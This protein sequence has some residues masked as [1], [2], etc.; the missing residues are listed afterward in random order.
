[1]NLLSINKLTIANFGPFEGTHVLELPKTGLVLIKGRVTE[2]EDG[3]GSGKSYLLKAL[4]YLFGGCADPGT[5][6]Q[7][8]FTDAPPEA[9]VELETSSGLLKIGRKKG[10]SISGGNYKET[11]KGKAAE[12]E[13]TNI[14]GIDEDSRSIVTYRGQGKPGLFLSLSDEKKKIFLS[15]LLGLDIYQNLAVKSKLKIEELEQKLAIALSKLNNSQNYLALS[16]NSLLEAE[17]KLGAYPRVDSQQIENLKQTIAQNKKQIVTLTNQIDDLKQKSHSESEAVCNSLQTKINEVYKRSQPIEIQAL[18]NELEKEKQRL[19]KALDF[20]KTNQFKTEQ[21]RTELGNAIKAQNTVLTRKP[22]VENEIKVLESRRA[23]LEQQKCSECKREWI[24][25]ESEQ[26]LAQIVTNLNNCKKELENFT[27]AEN[28]IKILTGQL[29]QIKDPEPNPVCKQATDRIQQI[30]VKAKETLAVFERQRQLDVA[31]LQNQLKAAKESFITRLKEQ[32]KDL[33]QKLAV[34]QNALECAISDDKKL[35][36]VQS[37]QRIIQALCEERKRQ[38]QSYQETYAADEAAVAKLSQDVALEKD[39]IALVGRQGFLGS[40]FEEVLVEISSIANNILSQIANVQHLSID[41]E[42]EKE[43]ATTGNITNRI[44]PVIYSRGRKVSYTSG[45][46]GGMQ[47][48]VMLA[49]DLAVGEVVSQRRGS[50]PGWLI[51]DESFDGLGGCAKE[52]CIEML[53]NYANDRLVLI[54]DHDASFQGLFNETIQVEQTDG[55][56]RI[57]T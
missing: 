2:T 26:T 17:Q 7:S 28:E 20:D 49:V 45:I 41:F 10:L 3:S 8:W 19:Q 44:T 54:V 4:A 16:K 53:K 31:D 46:S 11:I 27:V 25:P 13:L 34:T 56:S 24:G 40:I 35:V 52:S 37:Q 29:N 32:L 23:I 21:Q 5:A 51:L 1:L 55:R 48:A 47:T 6:I 39:I 57:V 15:N 12:S 14:F 22:K 36:E 9:V 38:T 33:N 50:Y 18:Q 30:N 43:A 42:T